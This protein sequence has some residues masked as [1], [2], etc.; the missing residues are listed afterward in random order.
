MGFVIQRVT[1]LDAD[2]ADLEALSLG[3]IQYHQ[4]WDARPLRPDWP[5]RMRDY[6]ALKPDQ[7]VMLARD[8][9]GGAAGFVTGRIQRSPGIFELVTGF[10]DNMFV[11]EAAR[12]QGVGSELLAAFEDWARNEGAAEILLHVNAQNSLGQRFWSGSGFAVTEHVMRRS[13]AGPP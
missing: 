9:A 12:A 7:I 2:W 3:I 11:A 5:Q 4:P 6:L 8:D 13:L 1:D 10:I